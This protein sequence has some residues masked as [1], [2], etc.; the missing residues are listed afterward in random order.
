MA[1]KD[2]TLEYRSPETGEIVKQYQEENIVK[3][4]GKDRFVGCWSGNK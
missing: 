1:R 4:A 2:G 3:Q